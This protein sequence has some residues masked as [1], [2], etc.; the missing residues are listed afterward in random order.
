MQRLNNIS[1]AVIS[2]VI[3]Q[4]E[5]RHLKYERNET[6]MKGNNSQKT[7]DSKIEEMDWELCLRRYFDYVETWNPPDPDCYTRPERSLSRRSSFNQSPHVQTLQRQPSYGS[8]HS[9]YGDFRRGEELETSRFYRPPRRRSITSQNTQWQYDPESADPY[10]ESV[11]MR[12][13]SSNALVLYNNPTQSTAV[14]PARP[15]RRAS[16]SGDFHWEYIGKSSTFSLLAP[17]TTRWP[18]LK[19]AQVDIYTQTQKMSAT[20]AR[21]YA[22][23]RLAGLPTEVTDEVKRVLS[24][25]DPSQDRQSRALQRHTT[26]PYV[27]QDPNAPRRSTSLDSSDRSRYNTPNRPP[28]FSPTLNTSLKSPAAAPV[29]STKT[30]TAKANTAPQKNR[31]FF[32]LSDLR[33]LTAISERPST[34]K[35]KA[36]S[37]DRP[38]SRSFLSSFIP[39][40]SNLSTQVLDTVPDKEGDEGRSSSGSD[41]LTSSKDL[42]IGS[43]KKLSARSGKPPTPPKSPLNTQKPLPPKPSGRLSRSKKTKLFAMFRPRQSQSDLPLPPSLLSLQNHAAM[44][45]SRESLRRVSMDLLKRKDS[46]VTLLSMTEGLDVPFDIWLRALPYIEGRVSTPRGL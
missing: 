14:A 19:D 4:S 37:F 2:Q 27:R 9:N 16:I 10:R 45:Q 5:R 34:S 21:A 31:S 11:N 23:G 18:E 32:S 22:Q 44:N 3:R 13:L 40:K 33:P 26:Q 35:S 28:S 25:R 1:D 30:T 8:I 38:A 20:E 43:Q 7:W 12:S 46:K 39:K 29:P 6:P 36:S 17:L 24:I 42:D 15:I 41:T